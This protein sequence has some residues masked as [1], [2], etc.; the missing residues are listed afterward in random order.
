M[1]VAEY[2]YWKKHLRLRVFR[3]KEKSSLPYKISDTLERLWRVLRTI[4]CSSSSARWVYVPGWHKGYEGL[5]RGDLTF[6]KIYK[7]WH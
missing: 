4:Y 2:Y 7:L 3:T 5:W 6:G 1:E